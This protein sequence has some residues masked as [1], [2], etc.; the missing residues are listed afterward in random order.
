MGFGGPDPGST[1]VDSRAIS[2]TGVGKS[3]G[4]IPASTPVG[5]EGGRE[6]VERT[7]AIIAELWS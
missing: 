3:Y 2:C 5:P 1:C 6:L 4:A 7:L